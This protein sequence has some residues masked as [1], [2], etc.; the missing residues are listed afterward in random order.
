M[1]RLAAQ[2]DD[3]SLFCGANVLA[4]DNDEVVR[5]VV[6][7]VAYSFGGGSLGTTCYE[8]SWNTQGKFC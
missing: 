7:R 6:K 8:A 5:E 2:Q 3:I 4:D 1:V